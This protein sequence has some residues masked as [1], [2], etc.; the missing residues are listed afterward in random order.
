MDVNKVVNFV[1]VLLVVAI[2]VPTG[3]TTLL[4]VD[5]AAWPTLL[6]TIWDFMPIMAMLGILLGIIA[7]ATGK[8]RGR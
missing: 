2:L 4:D 8:I 6:V 7:F 5:T 1:V 3:L